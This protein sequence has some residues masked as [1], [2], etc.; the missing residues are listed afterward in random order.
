MERA[1]GTSPRGCPRVLYNLSLAPLVVLVIAVVALAFGR[2][3]AEDQILSQVRG[4]IGSEGADAVRSMIEHAAKPTSGAMASIIGVITLLFGASGVFGE[5]RSALN[6]IWDVKPQSRSGL[7]G[8]IKEQFFSVGMVLA[9][10][11]LLLVSLLLSA[12]LAALGKFFVGVLPVPEMLLSIL[13]FLVSFV[14][15]AI[16]FA[17]IFKYV[18]ER[19]LPGNRC[20][21]EPCSL[22]FSSQSA[23]H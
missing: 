5:L 13:S 1:R 19:R 14:G 12:A 21:S 8:M 9:I 16:L 23:N 20:G 15:I 10:G 3:A 4:M 18:P 11:F 6:T 7:M 2:S 17:L 22:R